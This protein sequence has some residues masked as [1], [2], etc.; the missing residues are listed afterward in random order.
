VV[1][2][3][4]YVTGPAI[5]PATPPCSLRGRHAGVLDQCG[6]FL[7]LA[8]E[9]SLCVLRAALAFGEGHAAQLCE[10]LDNRV[11]LECL[12]QSGANL[13]ECDLGSACWPV[14]RIPLRDLEPC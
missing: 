5:D 11:I 8:P 4:P 13:I 1:V 10:A 3:G 14:E 9:H 7:D 6:P 2:P 12:L